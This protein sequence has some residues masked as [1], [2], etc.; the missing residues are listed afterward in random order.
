[1][2]TSKPIPRT[3]YTK[4]TTGIHD[5]ISGKFVER[6]VASGDIVNYYI[7]IEINGLKYTIKESALSVY[8][9]GTYEFYHFTLKYMDAFRALAYATR[10]S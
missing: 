9:I 3:I 1:M 8:E 10:L 5:K 2:A 4:E 7:D 6:L